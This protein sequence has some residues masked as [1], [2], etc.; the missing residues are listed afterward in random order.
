MNTPEQVKKATEEALA[1]ARKGKSK[2]PTIAEAK[3]REREI[4]E[5]EREVCRRELEILTKQS[6]EKVVRQVALCSLGTSWDV[7]TVDQLVAAIAKRGRRDKIEG[8]ILACE[9]LGLPS[10]LIR[11]LARQENSAAVVELTELYR[12]TTEDVQK[13]FVDGMTKAAREAE[14]AKSNVEEPDAVE[15][16][17]KKWSLSEDERAYVTCQKIDAIGGSGKISAIKALRARTGLGLYESKQ[18][19]D[20]YCLKKGIK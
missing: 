6:E 18:I 7:D 1:V 20:A 17:G 15:F 3:A 14:K 4:R 10:Y 8:F 13:A 9:T 11:R 2:R 5:E 16:Q 12:E 19:I